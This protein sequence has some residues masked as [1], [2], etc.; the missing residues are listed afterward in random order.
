M[1]LVWRVPTAQVRSLLF[2]NQKSAKISFIIYSLYY[3]F[4]SLSWKAVFD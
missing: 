1:Q 2:L 3:S 4:K